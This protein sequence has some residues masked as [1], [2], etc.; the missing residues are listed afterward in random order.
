VSEN[1]DVEDSVRIVA[2]IMSVWVG[3][4]KYLP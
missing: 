1:A 2:A 4:I 3:C